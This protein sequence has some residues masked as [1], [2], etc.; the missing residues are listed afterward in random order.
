[1]KL[2]ITEEEPP[3]YPTFER[4]ERLN[5]AGIK[6]DGNIHHLAEIMAKNGLIMPVEHECGFTFNLVDENNQYYT[7][8]YLTLVD[9]MAEK[10]LHTLEE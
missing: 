2:N 1:M 7:F 5:K 10:I 9:A 4:I 6:T 8:I 3:I